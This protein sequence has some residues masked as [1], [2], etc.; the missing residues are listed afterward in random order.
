MPILVSSLGSCSQSINHFQ[1]LKAPVP[2]CRKYSTG[3]DDRDLSSGSEQGSEEDDDDDEEGY[4]E[5]EGEEEGA[6]YSR[7]REHEG[8]AFYPAEEG[9]ISPPMEN[10]YR[11]GGHLA[12]PGSPPLQMELPGPLTYG[13]GGEME[14]DGVD[15]ARFSGDGSEDGGGIMTSG[16]VGSLQSLGGGHVFPPGVDPFLSVTGSDGSSGGLP[17]SPRTAMM[18]SGMATETATAAAAAAFPMAVPL[19]LPPPH[20]PPRPRVSPVA[21]GDGDNNSNEPGPPGMSIPSPRHPAPVLWPPAEGTA[22]T[23]PAVSEGEAE[24]ARSLTCE[25][26]ANSP[27]SLC[28]PPVMLASLSVS[29]APPSPRRQPSIDDE[30]SSLQTLVASPPAPPPSQ[31]APLPPPPEPLAPSPPRPPTPDAPSS[32]A[33]SPTDDGHSSEGGEIGGGTSSRYDALDEGRGSRG[34]GSGPVGSREASSRCG[35]GKVNPLMPPPPPPALRSGASYGSSGGGAGCRVGPAGSGPGSFGSGGS[36]GGFGTSYRSNPS[37]SFNSGGS[38]AGG[39]R[40]S[41]LMGPGGPFGSNRPGAGGGDP[42][43]RARYRSGGGGGNGRSNLYGSAPG[44]LGDGS[45]R[46][47]H[48][49]RGR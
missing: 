20:S 33:P 27:G 8:G 28:S 4:Y 11:E 30:M 46:R 1:G 21:G 3:D 25:P 18:S 15:A 26:G 37:G 45:A 32:E 39:G 13:S 38:G 7:Q 17:L 22:P 9:R 44:T 5:E 41:R 43:S 42:G 6:F 2:G 49:L 48:V 24:A 35:G 19:S 40:I 31:L 23:P 10:N 47:D 16:S 36:T 29:A 34:R 12:A 14:E